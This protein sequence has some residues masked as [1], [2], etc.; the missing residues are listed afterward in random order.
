MRFVT[1]FVIV[2]SF[3]FIKAETITDFDITRVYDGDTFYVNIKNCKY[4][5]LCK[6]I[7]IRVHGIDTP[8]IRTKSHT[9]KALGYLAKDFTRKF[10]KGSHELYLKNC[11]RGKYFRLVCELHNISGVSLS[12]ELIKNGLAVPYNGGTKT[13]IW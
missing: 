7:G 1:L 6:N 5:V 3:N 13:K 9:E 4:D 8:E 11:K 10:I 12:D 2:F